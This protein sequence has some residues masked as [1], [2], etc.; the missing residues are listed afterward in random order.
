MLKGLDFNRINGYLLLLFVAAFP[1]SRAIA[2]IFTVY[3][4]LYFLVKLF[5]K[6][7]PLTF[8]KH[9]LVVSLLLFIFYMLLS[10]LWNGQKGFYGRGYA[11]LISILGIA[12]YLYENPKYIYKT[13]SAFLFGM[14]ISEILSYGIFFKLWSINGRTSNDP[15][16]IM[17]HVTYSIFLAFTSLI[18]LNRIFSKKTSFKE[19]ILYGVFF[20]TVTTNLFI[21]AGRTGQIVFVISLIVLYFIHYKFTIKKLIIVFFIISSMIIGFYNI[22]PNF[23]N[24]LINA[25]N[26]IKAMIKGDYRQS[27][28]G[29]VAM[30]K[31]SFLLV[32][33]KPMFGY[34]VGG[35]GRGVKKLVKDKK[36]KFPKIL[37]YKMETSHL[38]NQFMQIFVEGGFIGLILFLSIIYN[39]LKLNIEDKE[40]K[41]L[42]IVFIV[43][44]CIGSFSDV[45]IHTQF[46]KILF[47]LFVAIFLSKE[48]NGTK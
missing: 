18:L 12:L 34:G 4:I 44:Y 35:Q 17:Y 29:R 25:Q 5:K 38:H 19:K 42:S 3:F 16:P 40:I 37:Q 43:I 33:E 45:L 27:I 23:K 1:L 28:G 15:T 6:K 24:R 7:I 32:K 47:I 14:L 21:N 30:L 39:I 22:S 10:N 48:L 20:T 46:T 2:S 41:D 36:I 31:T 9:P 26:D 8:F 11:Q 13:V